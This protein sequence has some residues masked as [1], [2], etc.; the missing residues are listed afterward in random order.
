MSP[1]SVRPCP[2]G[3]AA[4]PGAVA[5]R[6]RAQEWRWCCGHQT[7]REG[8]K[9]SSHLTAFEWA[10]TCDFQE[11]RLC[12]RGCP[13]LGRRGGVWVAPHHWWGLSLLLA[14][15]GGQ[16]QEMGAAPGAFSQLPKALE[17]WGSSTRWRRDA[18]VPKLPQPRCG[19][20]ALPPL[21]QAPAAEAQVREKP[22]ALIF[23]CNNPVGRA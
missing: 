22:P 11:S 16:D 17:L 6:G 1:I 15:P 14:V 13:P 19:C 4:D 5:S 12:W 10:G 8:T 23:A 20:W 18:T 3:C 7:D 21:G 9:H 2:W